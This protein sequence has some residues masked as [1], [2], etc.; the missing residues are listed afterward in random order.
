MVCMQAFIW[1]HNRGIQ[2]ESGKSDTLYGLNVL[3][4]NEA[5]KIQAIVGFRQLTGSE[6]EKYIKE[7]VQR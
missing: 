7:N 6:S 3:R 1:W 4:M 5:G 2:K